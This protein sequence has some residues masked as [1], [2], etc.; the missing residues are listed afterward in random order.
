MEHIQQDFEGS[1]IELWEVNH[2]IKRVIRGGCEYVVCENWERFQQQMAD[3]KARA[4]R[5]YIAQQQAEAY[6]GG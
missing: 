3:E 1:S 2:G 6:M 5:E 4:R